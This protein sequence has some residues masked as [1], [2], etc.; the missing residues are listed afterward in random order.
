M[1]PVAWQYK[2]AS[3]EWKIGSDYSREHMER[4]GYET[5]D[6]Y[7]IPEGH[8]VVP[9]EPT[10]AMICDGADAIAGN[11]ARDEE[12]LLKQDSGYAY[13]AMIEAAQEESE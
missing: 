3:G 11:G 5:R 4:N 2:T 13:K 12:Y 1:K 9:V 6:L 7:A 8:V 10:E